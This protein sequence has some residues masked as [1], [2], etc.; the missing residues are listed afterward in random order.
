MAQKW[1][2]ELLLDVE[3]DRCWHL[4]AQMKECQPLLLGGQE[5][6]SSEIRQNW[7]RRVHG[8]CGDRSKWSFCGLRFEFAGLRGF[9]RWSGGMSG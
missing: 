7:P 5:L 6:R 3:R 2:T 1:P 4:A 9:S 8:P